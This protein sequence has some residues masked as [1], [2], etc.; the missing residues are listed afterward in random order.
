MVE[1]DEPYGLFGKRLRRLMKERHLSQVEL[2]RRMGYDRSQI[3]WR[4]IHAKVEPT[5]MTLRRLKAALDCEYRDLFE[6]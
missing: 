3:V 2:A 4:F 1:E 5:Y 6:D